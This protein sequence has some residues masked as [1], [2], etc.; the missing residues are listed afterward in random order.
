MH[1]VLAEPKWAEKLGAE[2][3]RG[4]TAL[5]G[6]NVNP[7]GTFRLDMDKRI[8]FGLPLSVPHPRTPADA[9]DR[10]RAEKR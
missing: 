6:S 2:E 5:F 4:L 1:Q 9:G 10:P 7:Y 8:D 3:R